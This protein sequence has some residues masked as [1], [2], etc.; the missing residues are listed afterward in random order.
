MTQKTNDPYAITPEEI[1]KQNAQFSSRDFGL[2]CPKHH[3]NSICHVCNYISANIPYNKYPDGHPATLWKNERRAKANWFANVVFPENPNKSFII[4]LGQKVGDDIRFK[5]EKEQWGL[6]IAN[7]AQGK[8]R[9]IN[10]SK[11]KDRKWN[12]YSAG[13]SLEP[14]SYDI[15][16][17]VLDNLPN[18]DNIV[19]MIESGELTDDNFFNI[20]A[21]KEDETRTLRFCPASK[22]S[23]KKFVFMVP[24]RRHWKVTQGQ[25]DGTEIIP[26]RVWE[27]GEEETQY[28]ENEVWKPSTTAKGQETPTTATESP[29]PVT[30]PVQT[31]SKPAGAERC[32]GTP[33]LFDLDEEE[34]QNCNHKDSCGKEVSNKKTGSDIPM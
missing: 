5:C 3:K 21:L 14:A 20:S 33:E 15:P 23:S 4:Q 7:P 16:Q 34:C 28:Q 8:G 25:I 17:E 29:A 19:D 31:N 1:A 2:I 11:Y 26:S 30:P 18:L 24:V 6:W 13:A 9:E 27:L 12:A 10:I 32:W 22:D